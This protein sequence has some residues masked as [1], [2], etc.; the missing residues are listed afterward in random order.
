MVGVIWLQPAAAGRPTTVVTRV[1]GDAFTETWLTAV[2]ATAGQP[3]MH[4]L[5]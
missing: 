4:R 5:P 2:H 1:D 3:K